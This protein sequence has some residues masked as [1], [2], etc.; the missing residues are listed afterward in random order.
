MPRD[1][2][3]LPV[4]EPGDV[5]I[6]SM[7]AR[8][9]AGLVV[10]APPVQEPILL[11]SQDDVSFMNLESYRDDGPAPLIGEGEVPMIVA[12]PVALRRPGTVSPLKGTPMSRTLAA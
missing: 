8:D 3:P 11:A 1:N 12:P 2:D 5:A 4:V 6:I 7:D 9:A 10:A